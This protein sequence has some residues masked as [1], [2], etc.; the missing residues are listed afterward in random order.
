MQNTYIHEKLSHLTADEI[1]TLIKRYYAGDKIADLYKEFH[2]ECPTNYL[3]KLLPPIISTTDT[4]PNCG[5]EM[6]LCRPSRDKLSSKKASN[7][8]HCSK[9]RHVDDFLCKCPYCRKSKKDLFQSTSKNNLDVNELTCLQSVNRDIQVRNLSLEQAITLL[10][11]VR[12]C[13]FDRGLAGSILDVLENGAIPF[14]PQGEYGLYLIEKLLETEIIR[15]VNQ[16]DR[17]AYLFNGAA[18][19][20]KNPKSILWGVS[21]SKRSELIQEIEE[22]SQRKSW[23]TH[24]TEQL[25]EVMFSLA[26]A[27][28]NEF[29][30]WCAKQR[31]FPTA[32]EQSTTKMLVH[33]LQDYSVAQCYSIIYSGAKSAADF[34]VR[35]SCNPHHAANYMISA[36]QRWADQAKSQN[37]SVSTFNRNFE[38]P[39]SMVNYVL[40]DLFLMHDDDGFNLPLSKITIR[41]N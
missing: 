16:S 39:R 27:E 20:F 24:W 31:N 23:P 7:C 10:A 40:H 8:W 11:L 15:S 35:T 29:F 22:Y 25:Q 13:N 18:M 41:K 19:S 33:L 6:I 36:C 32:A 3:Y 4:C 9:C 5:G 17:D 37:K 2:I 1:D 26:Y 34:L 21:I 28:C 38:L 30:T 14:A 12:C